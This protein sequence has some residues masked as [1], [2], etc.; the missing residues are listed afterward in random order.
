MTGQ[1]GVPDL[2]APFAE[3]AGVFDAAQE[4]GESQSTPVEQDGLVDDVHA[5]LHRP[6]G[7]ISSLGQAFAAGT[8][9]VEFQL[10]CLQPV[11]M[12]RLQESSLMELAP[13][14]NAVQHRVRAFGPF[15]VA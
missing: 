6:Q 13:L 7:V 9:G 15:Q 4:I 12:Q 8:A 10:H 2:V 3:T 14:C 11:G 5:G 1:R